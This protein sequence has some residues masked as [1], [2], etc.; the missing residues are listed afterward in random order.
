MF[1]KNGVK[2]VYDA[3]TG[4]C[5]TFFFFQIPLKKV[6][7]VYIYIYKEKWGKIKFT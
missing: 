3:I 5:F 4:S 6:Q 2:K 1:G 7:D